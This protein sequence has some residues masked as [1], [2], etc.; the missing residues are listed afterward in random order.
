MGTERDGGCLQ[1]GTTS[2][3]WWGRGKRVRRACC[4]LRPCLL[5]GCGCIRYLLF[6][7][8]GS[9]Y[10]GCTF[11][12]IGLPPRGTPSPISSCVEAT[13]AAALPS[14]SSFICTRLVVL[15]FLVAGE[16]GTGR[17]VSHHESRSSHFGPLSLPPFF[18]PPSL[19]LPDPLSPP[20]PGLAVHVPRPWY[21]G[22]DVRSGRGAGAPSLPCVLPTPH[23]W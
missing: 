13:Q 18:H 3:C 2:L 22:E 21:F 19:P 14:L 16:D 10:G 9:L 6:S 5:A 1:S 17:V 15:V 12:R 20:L 23:Y 4:H 7:S 11:R 8:Y